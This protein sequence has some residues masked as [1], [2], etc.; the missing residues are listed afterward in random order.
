MRPDFLAG[1][2][3]LAPSARDVAGTFRA[4]FPSL[5]GVALSSHLPPTVLLMV[6]KTARE[7]GS[8]HR[9]RVRAILAELSD[10]DQDGPN[11]GQPQDGSP[12]LGRAEREMRVELT[13]R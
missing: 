4:M 7:F 2:V 13:E 11:V 6:N 12:R 5:T 1:F 8:T 10:K 3:S 9:P